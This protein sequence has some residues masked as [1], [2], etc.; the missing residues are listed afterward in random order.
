MTFNN[1]FTEALQYT[2][3]TSSYGRKRYRDW[4]E[5]TMPEFQC[6]IG[7]LFHMALAPRSSR[8]LYWS[9]GRYGD[10]FVQETF[11]NMARF[12]QIWVALHCTNATPAEGGSGKFYKVIVTGDI[13]V[14]RRA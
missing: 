5:L 10:A 9:K 12:E 13:G 6:F 2:I 11:P 4:V 1:L 7:V 8:R 14:S 3:S